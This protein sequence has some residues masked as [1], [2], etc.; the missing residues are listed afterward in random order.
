MDRVGMQCA[1]LGERHLCAKSYRGQFWYLWELRFVRRMR[2]CPLAEVIALRCWPLQNRK[3]H[4]AAPLL[5]QKMH[6]CLGHVVLCAGGRCFWASA[7]SILLDWNERITRIDAYL[8]IHEC[9]PTRKRSSR[10][11]RLAA[12]ADEAGWQWLLL[13]LNRGLLLEAVREGR[14]GARCLCQHETSGEVQD[15]DLPHGLLRR[16]RRTQAG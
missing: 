7:L 10:L 9:D 2:L 6:A 5:I 4:L 3:V 8:S 1:V 13:V 14:G 12:Y 15:R 11:Y 16:S